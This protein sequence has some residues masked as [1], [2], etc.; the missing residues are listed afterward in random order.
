MFSG[1]RVQS[2]PV[3]LR[4]EGPPVPA[5][6]TPALPTTDTSVPATWARLPLLPPER[7]LQLKLMTG[8]VAAQWLSLFSSSLKQGR[9]PITGPD[10][11]L[12]H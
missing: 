4:R 6:A 10:W 9:I 8:Y 12:R 5:D 2:R 3:C 11:G 7:H 1:S